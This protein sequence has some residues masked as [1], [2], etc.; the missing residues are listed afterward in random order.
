MPL[1][2]ENTP[3]T[4]GEL[5]KPKLKEWSTARLLI[6]TFSPAILLVVNTA[7]IEASFGGYDGIAWLFLNLIVTGLLGLLS[8]VVTGI[9]CARLHGGGFQRYIGYIVMWFLVHCFLY[10]TIGYAGCFLLTGL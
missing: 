7:L 9:Y 3:P 4:K 1:E 5:D 6:W 10:F 2:N 8:G